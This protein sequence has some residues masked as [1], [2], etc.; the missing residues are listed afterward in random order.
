MT[1]KKQDSEKKT[2]T[3]QDKDSPLHTDTNAGPDAETDGISSQDVGGK[4]PQRD[5][6]NQKN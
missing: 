4:A 5:V 1:E 2:S 6:E 3:K